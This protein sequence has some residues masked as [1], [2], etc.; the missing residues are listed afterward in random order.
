MVELSTLVIVA[1]YSA[2]DGDAQIWAPRSA[3][4]NVPLVRV[5]FG[6]VVLRLPLTVRWVRLQGFAPL[7]QNSVT[8]EGHG[9]SVLLR[10]VATAITFAR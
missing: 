6:L 3:P 4:V 9:C 7:L 8:G 2:F 5:T 10:P 1:P